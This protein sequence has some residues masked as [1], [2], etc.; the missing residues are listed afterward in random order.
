MVVGRRM[1]LNHFDDCYSNCQ[2]QLLVFLQ[3]QVNALYIYISSYIYIYIYIYFFYTK[4][5]AYSSVA[6][7]LIKL[8]H[9]TILGPSINCVKFQRWMGRTFYDPGG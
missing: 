2:C 6:I 9:R 3:F 8:L 4:A 5:F 7:S 1:H